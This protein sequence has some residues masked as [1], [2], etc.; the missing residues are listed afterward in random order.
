M[1]LVLLEP[2]DPDGR[3]APFAGVRPVAELRAGAWRIRERWEQ[4]LALPVSLIIGSRVKGFVDV[5]SPSVTAPGQLDAPVI[6]AASDFA[7]ATQ[8]LTLP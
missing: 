2:D 3:W 7:P 8:R 1:Q 4:A 5:D 6:I